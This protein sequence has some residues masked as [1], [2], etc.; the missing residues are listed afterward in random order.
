VVS[1]PLCIALD[2]PDARSCAALAEATSADAG[3]FKLGL[4]GFTAGGPELVRT[5]NEHRPV[6][7]DLK[8][9]DIPAQVAGAVEATAALGVAYV[10]V[11]ASGGAD[12]VRAAV[13]SADDRVAVVAVTVLT[14]FD[15]ATLASTGVAGPT[16]ERVLRLAELALRAGAHG[17]VCSPLELEALRGAYG[18]S[19]DSGPLLVTPGVRAGGSETHDQVRTAPLRAA[20]ERGADL[21]VVGRPIT[22]APDPRAAARRLHEEALRAR[23]GG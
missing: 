20:L 7:L 13:E 9:H 22:A 21:V 12:M 10:T 19:A 18:A 16:S 14:S 4:S 23:A 8:M 11:H 15:D 6:L 1:N 5:V 17:L 2:A 3:V